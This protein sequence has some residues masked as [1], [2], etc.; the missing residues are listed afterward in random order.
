M[1]IASK[2]TA[3][4]EIEHAI[5]RFD[6]EWLFSLDV[7]KASEDGIVLKQNNKRLINL[8]VQKLSIIA[9]SMEKLSKLD[10]ELYDCV[11]GQGRAKLIH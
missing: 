9:I 11:I 2:P 8:R 6:M 10:M 7:S 4:D 5:L 3:L 1:K